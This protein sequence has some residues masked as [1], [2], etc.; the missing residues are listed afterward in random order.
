[1]NTQRNTQKGFTLLELMVVLVIIGI[2]AAL[3]VPTYQGQVKRAA[4]AEVVS[5]TSPYKAAVAACAQKLS[6]LTGC[7]EEA[8]GIPDGL[9]TNATGKIDTLT[10]TGAGII[11]ATADDAGTPD[12]DAATY[13]LTPTYT[14]GTITWA[15]TGTCTTT[16]LC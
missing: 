16:G 14:A 1:M 11:T 4:F 3:A 2:L 6:T 8:H 13:I 7:V 10:V 5:A 9:A 15:V 12:L